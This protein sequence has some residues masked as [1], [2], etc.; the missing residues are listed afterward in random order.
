[1]LILWE[2]EGICLQPRSTLVAFKRRT[3]LPHIRKGQEIS[4]PVIF[5]I[6]KKNIEKLL[7]SYLTGGYLKT[8]HYNMN[9]SLH[10]KAS[11]QDTRWGITHKISVSV[12]RES[13]KKRHDQTPVQV[14]YSSPSANTPTHCWAVVQAR[15]FSLTQ[16]WRAWDVTV[17]EMPF[18]SRLEYFSFFRNP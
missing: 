17:Q 6:V 4:L 16:L 14:T 7:K 9:E 10:L 1:M 3:V 12:D 15:L 13:S 18:L 8:T 2:D 5:K 11:N